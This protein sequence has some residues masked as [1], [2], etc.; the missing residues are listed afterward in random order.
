MKLNCIFGF[1]IFTFAACSPKVIVQSDYVKPVDFKNFRT[2]R[3]DDSKPAPNF[4][5]NEANQ[6]RVQLAIAEQMEKRDFIQSEI[7]DLVI[8]I[9]GSI[10]FIRE[11]GTNNM[12]P[13]MWGRGWYDPYWMN[14]NR[15]PRDENQNTMIINVI[16]ELENELIWQG[17]A[18]GQFQQKKK[19]IEIVIREIV[20]EI[21]NEFPKKPTVQYDDVVQ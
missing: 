2:Y 21:F 10:A 14:N 3:F 5:F 11:T 16:D 18:T 13:A 19:H 15:A 17:V 12:G 9:N 8:K 4:T 6:D 1:L 20:Q 7:S